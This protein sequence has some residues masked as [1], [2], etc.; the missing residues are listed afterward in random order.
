MKKYFYVDGKEQKGPF[1]L[2]ELNNQSIT[3]KT[4]V[5][6]YGLKDWEFAEE[7]EELQSLF[8]LV[9]PPINTSK[10][11]SFF[12]INNDQEFTPPK[13]PKLKSNSSESSFEGR[14]G[15][16]TYAL[17]FFMALFINYLLIGL[18]N[19]ISKF[20]QNE[21]LK[22]FIELIIILNIFW[23]ILANGTKRCHDLG[24]NGWWQ[25]IPFY[26]IWMLFVEGEKGDNQYGKELN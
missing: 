1:T 21:D 20:I 25:F 6:F 9:P 8:E 23:I 3:R 19:F 12:E 4:L 13:I 11:S 15:R 16:V 14:V 26:F 24:K 17:Y 2:E 18:D 5:W 7:I 10:N 22:Y